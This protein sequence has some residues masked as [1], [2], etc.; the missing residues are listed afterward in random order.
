M[1]RRKPDEQVMDDGTR[2]TDPAAPD[3]PHLP[4]HDAFG[5]MPLGDSPNY[6]PSHAA[7]TT[8][9]VPSG[10]HRGRKI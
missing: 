2:P 3:A 10:I 1:R 5:A 9:P 7:T 8:K 6:V 4:A